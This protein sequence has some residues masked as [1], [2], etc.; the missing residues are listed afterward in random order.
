[1][2]EFILIISRCQSREKKSKQKD[3][4]YIF[5]FKGFYNGQKIKKINLTFDKGCTQEKCLTEGEDYLLWVKRKMI[6]QNI[7]KVELL[8]Y[9][10]IH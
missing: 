1:M 2:Q 7:L 10:K 6:I 3:P 9:K 4:I 5:H 8:K